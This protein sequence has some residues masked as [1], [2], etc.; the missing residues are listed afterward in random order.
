MPKGGKSGESNDLQVLFMSPVT[1]FIAYAAT[2]GSFHLQNYKEEFHTPPP[3]PL[4]PPL[5][6]KF[7][8]LHKVT[9]ASSLPSG[10]KMVHGRKVTP[11]KNLKNY[12]FF[13][14]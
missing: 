7:E 14:F 6:N 10:P 8:I 13:L 4:T 9:P 12:I 5:P 1:L 2:L 11:P 3:P